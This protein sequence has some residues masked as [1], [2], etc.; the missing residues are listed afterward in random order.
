MTKTEKTSPGIAVPGLAVENGT[1]SQTPHSSAKDSTT[2]AVERQ[3]SRISDLLHPGA[4]NA[5][6]RRELMALT[7]FTDRELRRMIEAERR[8]G[9]PILSN[10]V[11]GYY[12]P[13]DD[14]ERKRFVNSML[15]RAM[16]IAAVAAAVELAEE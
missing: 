14:T 1:A 13:A 8:R 11:G 3:P 15:H 7:G 9:V 6:P 5:I 2:P 16:E 12:L 10:C 4:E